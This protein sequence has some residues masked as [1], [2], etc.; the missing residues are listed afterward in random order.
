MMDSCIIGH[1]FIEISGGMAYLKA[2][3]TLPE[4]ES[5]CFFAVPEE[6]ADILTAE[7][8]DC[9]VA[10]ALPW[11]MRNKLSIRSEAPVS[12]F[13]LYSIKNRLIPQMSRNSKCYHNIEIEAEAGNLVLPGKGYAGTGWSGG[14]DCMYTLM[15]NLEA[16][17]KGYRLTHLLNINAGVFEEPDIEGKFDTARKLCKKAAA[18]FGLESLSIDT[19]IHQL[20][21]A[22][23][24]SVC[25]FR[26]ASAMLAL[27][28]GFKAYL[29]SSTYDLRTFDYVDDNA[30]FYEY[31]ILSSLSNQNIHFVDCGCEV[32]RI[33]KLRQ[34][35]DFKPAL[36]M[37]QVCVKEQDKNCMRCGKCIR[38]TAALYALGKL[39]NFDRVF[40]VPYFYEHKDE[41]L[42]DILFHKANIHYGEIISLIEKKGMEFSPRARHR[43]RILAA[44]D[45]AAKA[46][47][48]ALTGDD[49]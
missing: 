7:L 49:K 46:H 26:I 43:A 24:L 4:G 44:A 30:G 40:D 8:A 25:A 20:F 31:A 33:E 27:Q 29:F 1:P 11:C 22:L 37:L 35:S 17:E 10:A 21:P 48:S 13:L 16:P 5:L 15:H 18:H 12:R 36:E 6:Y 2:R 47:A 19:N 14:A 38:T 32:T 42:G 28:K 9:F 45:K 34:I 39:E 23:Y 41:I 3:I